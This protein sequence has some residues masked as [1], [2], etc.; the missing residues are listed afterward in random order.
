MLYGGSA[1]G[2]WEYYP[3]GAGF[4]AYGSKYHSYRVL[5]L[6]GGQV[7]AVVLSTNLQPIATEANLTYS[8]VPR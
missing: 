2:S 7:V 1:K 5:E 3:G 6:A 4:V 8:W